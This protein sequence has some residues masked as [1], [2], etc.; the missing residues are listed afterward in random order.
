MSITYP[1]PWFGAGLSDIVLRA[2]STVGTSVSPFTAQEQVQVF[3]GQWWEADISFPAMKRNT[4]EELISTLLSLNGKEGT[5]LMP[6]P[7][8]V[9]P[10]GQASVTPGTP[11]VD[12]EGQTGNTLNITGAPAGTAGW[13]L[14]GDYFQLGSGNTARL[15][16][17]LVNVDIDSAGDGQ[18]TFWP[19]L[20][21][22]PAEA[23][24][25]IVSNAQGRFRLATN[26]VQ[27]SIDV[28]LFYGL[29]FSV[30][31]AI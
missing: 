9:V 6:D 19:R 21:A 15:Y 28:A 27:F 16:K 14:K 29:S 4:A 31:E 7:N 18:I 5:F 12:G 26:V 1:L 30:R 3:P 23:A 20:R 25:V 2:N 8:G 17:S 24:P 10:R 11:V 13:L 22:S